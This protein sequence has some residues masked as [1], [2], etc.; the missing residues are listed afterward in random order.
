MRNKVVLAETD[1][2]VRSGATM[3]TKLK[4]NKHSFKMDL[5]F[6]LLLLPALILILLFKYLPMSGLVLAFKDWDP[7][8]GM[9]ASPWTDRFGFGNFIKLF[10][11]PEFVKAI[12]NTL[13]FNVV[14]VLFEFPAP[15]ILALLFN[16]IRNKQFKKVAQT[17]SFLPHFLSVAAVTGIVNA[18]LSKY[19]LINSV[20]ERIG[21]TGGQKLLEN[22][23]AFLP[24]FV[25]TNVWKNVGWG[26]LVYLAAICSLSPDLYEAAELDGAGRF[27]QTLYVTLPGMFPTIGILLI[28]KMGTLFNSSFEMVYGLQNPIGWTEEVIATSVYKYGLNNG[29]YAMSTALSLMQG[30][31]A[32]ILTFGANFIS[33]KVSNVAMW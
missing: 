33:K 32:L 29:Q 13:Y 15:I 17:I 26:T 27:K 25:L 8:L 11:T 22:P 10:Q 18:L 4:E 24:V 23:S 9:Y 7:K 20:M 31:I 1:G 28:M 14:T 30:A 19:G 16:E 21:I 12:L 5:P 6:Y 3:R 2:R